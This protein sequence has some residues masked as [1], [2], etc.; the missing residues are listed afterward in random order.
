MPLPQLSLDSPSWSIVSLAIT[1][2]LCCKN[3]FLSTA[4]PR[5]LSPSDAAAAAAF[6][7]TVFDVMD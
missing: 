2:D 4:T 7:F 6:F 5:C 3:F 1:C